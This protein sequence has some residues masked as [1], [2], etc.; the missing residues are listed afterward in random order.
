M[1][2]SR[3]WNFRSIVSKSMLGLVLAVMTGSLDVSPSFADDHGR[4]EGRDNVRYENR[5][6][7][8]ERDRNRREYRSSGYRERVYVP[9]PVVYAPAPAPGIGIFFPP[10][11]IR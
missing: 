11:F 3:R 10:I 6:R 2:T 1:K 9:P 5:G 4:G 8:H 7:G